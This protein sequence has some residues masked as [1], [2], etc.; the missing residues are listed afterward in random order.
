MHKSDARY[1]SQFER[2]YAVQPW[3]KPIVFGNNQPDR[4]TDIGEN[5]PPKPIFLHKLYLPKIIYRGYFGKYCF[6]RKNC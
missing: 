5:V 1:S 3:V 4:I 2:I 6:L